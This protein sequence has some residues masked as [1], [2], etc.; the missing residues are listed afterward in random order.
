MR[1]LA[2][3]SISFSL[4][5]FLCNYVF[6]VEKIRLY[7]LL[8]II[9][10]AVMAVLA[11]QKVRKIIAISLFGFVLGVFV[12][13]FAVNR[14]VLKL[15]SSFEK[16][17][18][19]K[20]TICAYEREYNY[21]SQSQ[22]RITEGELRG[23]RV[24]FYLSNG[25]SE[26]FVPGEEII[27]TGTFHDP[28][29]KYDS[30]SNYYY[31]QG[32]FLTATAD[33]IEK[34]GN[35]VNTLETRL[36]HL[37][38]SIR[39]RITELFSYKDAAFLQALMLGDKSDFSDLQESEALRKAGLSHIIAV[40]GMHVS[41]AV[42]VFVLLFGMG[43]VGAGCSIVLIWLF[44]ILTGANPSAVRAGFMQTTLLFAPIVRR[45]NDAPTSLSFSLAILLLQNPFAC[46]DIGLQLSYGAMAGLLLFSGKL[47][48]L[49]Q[50]IFHPKHFKQIFDYISA[51]VS[52]SISILFFTLP[53]LVVHFGYVSVASPLANILV[54]WSVPI[55]FVCGYLLVL[56][57]YFV[58]FVKLAA[59]AVHF[60]IL[61]V[62]KASE[63]VGGIQ[64]SIIY[65]S[66]PFAV[67]WMAFFYTAV[68]PLILLKIRKELKVLLASGYFIIS[69]LLTSLAGKYY[70]QIGNTISVIDVG[71]GQCISVFCED[72]TFLIDCGSS[73]L[74]VD[75]AENAFAYL[76]QCGRTEIDAL[77]ITHLHSD[78]VNGI[79]ELMERI[80]VATLLLSYDVED[81]D[82][83]L[84][85]ILAQADNYGT[86]VRQISFDERYDFNKGSFD[87]F[88]PFGGESENERCLTLKIIL[89][90]YSA[91]I[92]GD[93]PAKSEKELLI[94]HDISDVDL[95][96]VG[97]HG[98]KYSTSVE[99]LQTLNAR[100]AVISTGYNNYG[101]PTSETL[102]RLEYFGYTV[103]RTDKNGTVE[104]RVGE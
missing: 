17:L 89:G 13:S 31:A 48:Q 77:F 52:S 79:L 55:L 46:A 75:A 6:Y 36:L 40:S 30:N 91:L 53:L 33:S 58:P 2:L 67:L 99:L 11:F 49:F 32:I 39:Q 76:S 1:K 87:L 65:M 12:F 64:H 8:G 100:W 102:Q 71:Q 27:F 14:N 95:Y 88:A 81:P 101:H 16:E 41:F 29:K 104:F 28:G 92:T 98:S 86:E 35:R 18:R 80:P 90:D 5:V 25:K 51:A 23:K 83:I 37:S 9:A 44:V 26:D 3:F 57:S 10:A 70:Y 24:L 34:T 84:P 54:L 78:H 97:H 21:Y 15:A 60:L 59:P 66:S 43:P 38:F 7:L 42:S 50:S 4:A 82:G 103:F 73:S 22:F 93:M 47:N 19:V 61:Y 62:F 74:N 94:S 45:E 85:S 96:V 69:V 56:L 20:G 63:L 68:I 72:R